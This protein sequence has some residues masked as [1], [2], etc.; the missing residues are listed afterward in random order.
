MHKE[1]HN[2]VAGTKTLCR[3]QPAAGVNN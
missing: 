3:H 1:G 2:G